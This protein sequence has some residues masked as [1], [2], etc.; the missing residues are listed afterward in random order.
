M[1][2]LCASGAGDS[3]G[4]GGEGKGL[5]GLPFMR[6]AKEQQQRASAAEAAAV[7]RSIE[8]EARFGMQLTSR[9]RDKA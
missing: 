5:F 4:G 8:A 7:L 3:Q 1:V 2:F 6:R 9:R